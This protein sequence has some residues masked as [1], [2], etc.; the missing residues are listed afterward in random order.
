[1]NFTEKISLEEI[2]SK[3]FKVRAVEPES[4]KEAVLTHYLHNQSKAVSKFYK[5]DAIEYTKEI[6]QYK[7]P[8]E[9]ITSVVAEDA[10]QY[11]L[12]DIYEVPFP[13]TEN[14][15][16]KFIDLFAGIGG[17]RLALQNLGGK[18]VFTSEWDKEAKRTYRANFG[19]VPFGDIIKEEI[20]QLL[21]QIAA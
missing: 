16:F 12:F 18:C 7:Y 21:T 8:E 20:Q 3:R 4:N 14:P 11:G 6:L 5:K 2:N 10:I 19:E 15:K 1:M 17:F 13:P 9:T